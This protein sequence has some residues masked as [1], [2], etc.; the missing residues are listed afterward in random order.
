MPIPEPK[1]GEERDAFINRCMADQTMVDE[2]DD[3][4]VRFAVCNTKFTKKQLK[5]K[6]GRK[7]I[8]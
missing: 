8:K 2:Y 6:N 4:G 1:T 7:F 3:E 5:K